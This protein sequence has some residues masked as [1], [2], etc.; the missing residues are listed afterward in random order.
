MA[1]ALIADV[2]PGVYIGSGDGLESGPFVARI[3]VSPA[4][5]G[6]LLIDYEATS[7]EEG[8]QHREHTILSAGPDGRDV[9]LVA[10]SE[11]P[12]VTEMIAI[13]P[14]SSHFR[15]REPLGPYDL[16]IVIEIPEPG[17]VAYAWH[18]AERGEPPVEQS[19]ADVRLVGS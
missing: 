4:P 7:R 13:E 9:L 16:E 15:Q 10:H 8:L 18:W 17:R 14:G 19:K 6:G 3:E 2:Q 11:S 1:M 5:N 12:F